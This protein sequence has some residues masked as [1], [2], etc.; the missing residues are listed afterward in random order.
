MI[1]TPKLEQS[2]AQLTAV[3]RLTIPRSEIQTVM[4][5]GIRELLTTLATQQ[6]APTGPVFSHHFNMSPETFDFEIGVPVTQPVS[7][8]GRVKPGALPAS[9]VARTLYHGAY[10][11]LEAAWGELKTWIAAN[12]HRT[13]ADLWEVYVVNPESSSDPAHWRTELNWPLAP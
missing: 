6:V 5:P 8:S 11:G 4:G 7:P 9:T 1:D 12:G 2:E 13:C 3:I 10:E